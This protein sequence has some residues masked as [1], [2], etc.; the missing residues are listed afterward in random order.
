M[1]RAHPLGPRVL[2]READSDDDAEQRTAQ[3]TRRLG[4]HAALSGTAGQRAA[5]TVWRL[6]LAA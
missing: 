4:A 3:H 1:Y 2:R 5:P 6:Q